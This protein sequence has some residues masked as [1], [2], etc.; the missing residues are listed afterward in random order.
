MRNGFLGFGGSG[1]LLDV[2]LRRAFLFFGAHRNQAFFF[3]AA[4]LPPMR[5]PFFAGVLFVFFPRPEPLSL[6]PPLDL[7]TVAHARFFA[8]LFDTPRFS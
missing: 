3:L 1:S 5:P 6:P 7:L 4:V 2:F 8:T